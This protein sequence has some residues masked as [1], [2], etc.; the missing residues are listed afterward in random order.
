LNARSII[1]TCLLS[2]F[3]L[4]IFAQ[5]QKELSYPKNYFTFPI[6]PGVTNHLS[7]AL[8]DLRT[9][10][11]H[12]GLDIKT[13]QR[14][15]LEV[16]AAADGYIQE[17]RISTSGYGNGLYIKHPNG[18]VTVYGHLRS[19]VGKIK[20]YAI[21]KRIKAESFELSIKPEANEIPVRRGELI[22][23]SGNTGGSGGP[24]LHFEI[25]NEFNNLLN[26]L[27]FGFSEI[28]DYLPPQI[29]GLIAKPLDISARVSNRY[30]RQY[31]YPKGSN[32]QYKLAENIVAKGQIGFE[33][34]AFDKMNY[35]HNNY[36]IS[37][38]E[39][40]VNQKEKFYYHLEKI[41]VEDSKD[42]NIH[43]DY[44]LEKI[45]GKKFQRLYLADGNN[46]LPIYKTD[47]H[48]GRLNI[49]PG[50]TYNIEIKCWDSFENLSTLNFDI[51]G[52][53]STN[54]IELSPSKYPAS[55]NYQID[56]NTLIINLENAK[57]IDQTCQ[58]GVNGK[59]VPL[60]IDYIQG[61]KAVYLYD[62]RQ[63]L[64]DYLEIDDIQEDFHFKKTISAGQDYTLKAKNYE[65][66]FGK[67]S[68]YDTLHLEMSKKNGLY[69]IGQNT[70][71]LREAI[72]IQ[73]EAPNT[74]SPQ[75]ASAY[76]IYGNTK[77]YLESQW[78][79]NR[80][81][82]KSR[83][84]GSFA[85]L[86]DTTAPS[87][88]ARMLNQSRLVFR[89]AD[90]LSGIKNFRAEVD[91]KFVLMDYDYKSHLI[92]TVLTDS[93]TIYTGDLKLQVTDNQGNIA[94]YENTIDESTQIQPKAAATKKKKVK[95][96]T[97]PRKSKTKAKKK[98]KR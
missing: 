76:W 96:G 55:T 34:L 95:K 81:H 2:V 80:I 92:W 41:P 46:Q 14:E 6:K 65:L 63:G 60:Q 39:V 17:I 56:E 19:Y 44:G 79:G 32:G 50:K 64:P 91:G 87:I 3:Y 31:F 49:L 68:L 72:E 59:I 67:K 42:I 71:P 13:D 89:I 10:H 51:L 93:T 29:Q 94:I 5:K 53:T 97:K 90:D 15:G 83:D 78:K 8:G 12:G 25:R 73:I 57:Y 37:C 84:L 9:N 38:I 26:P 69:N 98:K 82:F 18:L 86:T 24:H 1:L 33:L 58:L 11:F 61:N 20:E 30:G 77:R 48:I 21:Q 28:T 45:T 43:T 62:L 88:Q 66:I 70:I 22:A 36:G 54:S 47:P 74:E 35:N 85:I 4:N 7:G 23:Y 75:W 16:Y 40:L 27:Y 52:D